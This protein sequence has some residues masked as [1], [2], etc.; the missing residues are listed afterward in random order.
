MKHRIFHN[1]LSGTTCRHCGERH[2]ILLEND[3]WIVMKHAGHQNY[4][5]RYRGI[6]YCET[7]AVLYKKDTSPY[8]MSRGDAYTHKW[9]PLKHKRIKINE[10]KKDC[11]DY[12]NIEFSDDYETDQWF[13]PVEYISPSVQKLMD[14]MKSIKEIDGI[15][16]I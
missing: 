3:Q 11:K 2:E 1:W 12:Y 16:L 5:D 4:V 13:E 7:Y 10:I 9:E 6:M 8:K 15:R 14:D